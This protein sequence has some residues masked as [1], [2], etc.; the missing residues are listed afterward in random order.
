MSRSPSGR[1]CRC[2]STASAPSARCSLSLRSIEFLTKEQRDQMP[3]VLADIG[4]AALPILIR[5]LHDS[6]ENVRAVAAGAV[7]CLHALDALPALVKLRR[8]PSEWVR[9]SM[10]EALGKIGGANWGPGRRRRLLGR[11]L[12]APSRLIGWVIWK[13]GVRRRRGTRP[14]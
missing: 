11:A 12:G 14:P 2:R 3:R 10:V 9:E 5:H 7:G 6:H 4:P 13:E 1:G 8:D